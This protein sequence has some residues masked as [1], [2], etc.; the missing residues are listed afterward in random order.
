MLMGGGLDRTSQ[1][2]NG[3]YYDEQ[4]KSLACALLRYPMRGDYRITSHSSKA[5]RHPITRRV[6]PHNGV[7]FAMPPGT[8]VLSTGNGVVTRVHKHPFAGKYVEIQH[9]SR[10]ASRYLHLSRIL[11]RPGQ[12]VK[13]GTRIAF[14]GNTGRSTGPHLHYEFHVGGRPVNPLTARIPVA[15]SVPKEK[16]KEFKHKVSELLAMMEHPSQKIVLYHAGENS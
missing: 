6:A 16:L 7:D 8:P 13:R 11:V 14:S 5:R 1:S 15:S 9:G 12:T 3:N 10:Y 2:P 4:D